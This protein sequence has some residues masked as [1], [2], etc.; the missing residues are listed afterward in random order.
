MPTSLALYSSKTSA[1]RLMVL[2]LSS[3]RVS[4]MPTRLATSSLN[5]CGGGGSGSSFCVLFFN[6]LFC[7]CFVSCFVHDV[8]VCDLRN[9]HALGQLPKAR[10]NEV[11][12][13]RVHIHSLHLRFYVAKTFCGVGGGRGW[14]REEPAVVKDE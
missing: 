11:L 10:I 1:S 9:A 7:V 14:G 2:L 12:D 6:V 4:D 5:D 3:T 8:V 13:V